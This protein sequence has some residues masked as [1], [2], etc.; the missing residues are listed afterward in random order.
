MTLRLRMLTLVVLI[1]VVA[2]LPSG[3]S[4]FK[5]TKRVDLTPFA[6]HLI[7]MSE[8]IQYG[9]SEER[10]IWLRR[11]MDE[12]EV[13]VL[14]AEYGEVTDRTRRIL[15][16]ILTYSIEVVTL[17]QLDAPG[18]E[19]ADALAGYL[20]H[21]KGPAIDAEKFD[22]HIT[23]EEFDEILADIRTRKS[24][25]DGI[26]AAQPVADEIARITGEHISRVEVL[27]V[28]LEDAIT[29]AID[30]EHG[31]QISF[32]ATIKKQHARALKSL[33]H[34]LDYAD[35]DQGAIAAL[36]EHDPVLMGDVPK[37]R[38][39]NAVEVTAL[40]DKLLGRLDKIEK[41]RESLRADLDAYEMELG[42]LHRLLI[43]HR[44]AVRKARALALAWA[45]AHRKLASGIVD[46]A[47]IDMFGI[48]K[49]L[50]KGA[51]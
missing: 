31:T 13:A 1:T 51:L 45:Q 11:Y 24:L 16:G 40:V 49:S 41:V 17:A 10:A 43:G 25:V 2:G 26:N 35:G 39:P 44:D 33:G 23:S 19:K 12:P 4:T 9:L 27:Q 5:S 46:P 30:D 18:P 34:L 37:R 36:R 6:Q 20:E 29:A 48:T 22:V 47:A 15:R 42:E 8:D 28:K 50:I 3:C 14:L 32:L 7:V 38:D 21:L